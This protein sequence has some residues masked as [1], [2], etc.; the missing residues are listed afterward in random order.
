[1]MIIL[2]FFSAYHHDQEKVSEILKNGKS[3]SGGTGMPD[4]L[5]SA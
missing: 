3:V 2:H 1:M 5:D 4:M